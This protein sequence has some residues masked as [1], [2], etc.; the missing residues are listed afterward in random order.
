ML[1]APPEVLDDP[2][3]AAMRGFRA[4]D[5]Q[6]GGGRLYTTVLSYLQAA[7]A[8]CLFGAAKAGHDQG[9]FTAASALT[10]MVDG[11]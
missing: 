7:V 11:A 3:L 8:P 5:L 6:V 4:A 10:E 2:D 1:G 9:I